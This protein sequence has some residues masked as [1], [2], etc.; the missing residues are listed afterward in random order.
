MGSPALKKS[1][2]VNDPVP[3]AN[4]FCGALTGNRK[5]KLMTNCCINTKP[6]GFTSE[7][8]VEASTNT[9][10]I[11]AEASAVALANPK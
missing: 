9:I 5:P 11:N 3:Y 4:I 2:T 7:P 6:T 8:S 1:L 10:G